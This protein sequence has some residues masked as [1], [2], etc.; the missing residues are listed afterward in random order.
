MFVKSQFTENMKNITKIVVIAT[1]RLITLDTKVIP[2]TH[3]LNDM[4][5]K[6]PKAVLWN[7]K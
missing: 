1:A 2:T 4:W 3:P 6:L 7:V 5:R